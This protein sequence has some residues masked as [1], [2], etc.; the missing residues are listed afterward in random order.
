[1]R[2]AVIGL[3]R[4][5]RFYAEA[6]AQS[7]SRAELAAVADPNPAARSAVQSALG[8]DAAYADAASVQ[9]RRDI[10]AVIVATTT[11]SHA[12]VVMAAAQ[13]GKAI[14]CEKPLALTV[15]QTRQVL[16]VVESKRALLQIG[17]MRRFDPAHLRA[18]AL[19]AEGRIGRPLTYRSIGRDPGC[20]PPGY[21]T[22]ALSGGL[23]I[24]MGI[25]DFD[26][27][28][29]LMASDVERV[30]AEGTQLV[31]E[32]LGKVG[33]WD[34]ASVNLR[35]ASGAVG[36]VEVSRTAKYGYDIRVEVLG[37]E[38]AV[39]LGETVASQDG[40]ALLTPELFVDDG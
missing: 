7:S 33:D 21:A 24:D 19:I 20:P 10:D 27:A 12:E 34:N 35:F 28:R 38:G 8:V 15:E 11:S 1:M 36:S 17:F 5:G 4:M 6:I 23:I 2:I 29:W 26:A 30:S 16:D 3:G 22:P 31:C 25:H 32:E 14:F 9:E 13:A 37:S 39:R 40:V 18:R